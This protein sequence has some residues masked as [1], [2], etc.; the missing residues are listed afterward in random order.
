MILAKQRVKDLH[1]SLAIP[2][3]GR[4]IIVVKLDFKRKIKM[5]TPLD[6][7]EGI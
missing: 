6:K 5:P 4:K 3:L 7:E 1:K 2:L